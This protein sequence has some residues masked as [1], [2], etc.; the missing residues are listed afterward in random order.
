MMPGSVAGFIDDGAEPAAAAGV[1]DTPAD[2]GRNLVP[3]HCPHPGCPQVVG[4]LGLQQ[5]A[6]WCKFGPHFTYPHCLEF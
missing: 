4:P 1:M 3:V 5:H 6:Q 2:Y